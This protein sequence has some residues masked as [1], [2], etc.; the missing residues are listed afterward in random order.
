MDSFVIIIFS[1]QILFSNVLSINNGLR[2]IIQSIK[3]I[4]FFS[5]TCLVIVFRVHRNVKTSAQ[6][7]GFSVQEHK[8]D[9]FQLI[10]NVHFQPNKINLNQQK[11]IFTKTDFQP[12]NPSSDQGLRSIPL[13]YKGNFKTRFLKT[14]ELLFEI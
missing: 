7:F 11:C 4:G 1:I 10:K 8:F 6:G 12:T 9:S 5:Q 13:V 14:L 3:S 2:K